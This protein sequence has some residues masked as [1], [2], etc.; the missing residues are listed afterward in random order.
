MQIRRSRGSY[1]S[2]SYL[3]EGQVVSSHIYLLAGFVKEKNK[4]VWQYFMTVL[5][6]NNIIIQ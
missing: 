5:T 2:K 3:K 1:N 6:I 4:K